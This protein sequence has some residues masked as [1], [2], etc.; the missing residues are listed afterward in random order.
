MQLQ[1]TRARAHDLLQRRRARVVPLPREPK[2]HRQPVRRRE[3]LAHIKRARCA[4]RRIRPRARARPA[5]DHR[6]RPRG[7]RLA[8]LLRA[9]V[10]HVHVDRA[11][12]Q[13]ELLA[14][15][16]LRGGPDDERG[17]H[18]RHDVWVPGFADPDDETVFDTYVGLFLYY[19]IRWALRDDDDG[20]AV[21]LVDPRP[22]ND[23]SVG[24]NQVQRVNGGAI[25]RLAH[26]FSDGL[27]CPQDHIRYL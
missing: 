16:D 26:S 14:G 4:R 8:D 7:E 12:G 5:A 17:V 9:D 10:V 11:R 23:E 19:D 18:V 21:Y 3:H 13:D 24:D 6:R 1:P 27:T 2:V 25:C 22:V 15:D 20:R